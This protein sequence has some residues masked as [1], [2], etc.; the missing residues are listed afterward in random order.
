MCGALVACD[1]AVNPIVGTS[2]ASNINK[3][4]DYAASGKPVL[5]TQ[6]SDEYRKLIDKYQMGFNCISSY[7][8]FEYLKVLI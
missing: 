2:I 5:N 4:A 1:M 8:L 6:K 7:D 3:H